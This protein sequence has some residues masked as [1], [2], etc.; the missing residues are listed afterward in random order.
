MHKVGRKLRE[1]RESQGLRMVDVRTAGRELAKRRG[2][3]GY[4]IA[5]SRLVDYES[6][7]SIPTIYRMELFSILYKVPLYELMKTFGVPGTFT[8]DE[9]AAIERMKKEREER[10]LKAAE[11]ERERK[12]RKKRGRGRRRTPRQ[13]V[14]MSRIYKLLDQGL[15]K[16]EVARRVGV[17]RQY[18]HQIVQQRKAAS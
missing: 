4:R 18:I 15:R 2:Y 14:R 12:Q 3:R 1:L 13:K 16:A 17:S 7:K 6:D 5:L 11:R 8:A 9:R 10:W